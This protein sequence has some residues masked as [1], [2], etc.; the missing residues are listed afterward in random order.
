MK[1]LDLQKIKSKKPVF[2][3]GRL[4]WIIV[5]IVFVSFFLYLIPGTI[6]LN[7]LSKY[8]MVAKARIVE[9]KKVGSK[10]II[11]KK[12]IFRV[13]DKIYK[14]VER[15]GNYKI[16]DTILVK[17]LENDPSYNREVNLLE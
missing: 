15:Y 7:Y 4:Y 2:T 11:E 17:Y 10:G 9:L 12:Y 16:G 13:N 5:V 14:G 8:G 6:K 1:K 3:W